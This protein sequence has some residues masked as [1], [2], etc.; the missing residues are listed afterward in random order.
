M[1]VVALIGARAGSSIKD[2]NIRELAGYP[3]LAYSIRAALKAR[4]VHRVIVSTDSEEYAEIA[5][6]YG[7]ECPFL[8]PP[9]LATSSAT[10]YGYIRHCIEYLEHE[11]EVPDMIVQLR[12]TTPIRDPALQLIDHAIMAMRANDWA[13]SLR[14][15]HELQE[16]IEKCFFMHGSGRLW[17]ILTTESADAANAPRQS[18]RK[19]WFPNGYVDIVLPRILLH[20]HHMHGPSPLGFTTPRVTEFDG[21][22]EL[23]RLEYE[24]SRF[25]RIVRS[26]FDEQNV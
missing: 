7:A 2:K 5:R 24:A 18:L 12:P 11:S 3:V 6:F 8:R 14:S 10:D 23:Q 20:G 13:T 25:P 1:S 26:L 17:P 22:E 19:T 16:P 15:V 21:E 9:E 4:Y